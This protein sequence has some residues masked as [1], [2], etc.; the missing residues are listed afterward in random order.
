MIG[1]QEFQQLRTATLTELI[2]V[3]KYLSPETF[4]ISSLELTWEVVRS[5]IF[6][7]FFANNEKPCSCPLTKLS[8]EQTLIS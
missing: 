1:L 2:Y 7:F 5:K 3:L 6:F 8:P 4:S